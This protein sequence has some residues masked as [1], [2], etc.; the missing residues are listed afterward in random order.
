MNSEVRK[1]AVV[2]LTL[3]CLRIRWIFYIIFTLLFLSNLLINSLLF[4]LRNSECIL[5]K[6][7]GQIITSG[8]HCLMV[9]GV[10]MQHIKTHVLPE[11]VPRGVRL[12]KL[13]TARL[14][15]RCLRL[16][17]VRHLESM[18]CLMRYQSDSLMA[19]LWNKWPGGTQRGQTLTRTAYCINTARP[20]PHKHWVKINTRR[21][22]CSCIRHSWSQCYELFKGHELLDSSFLQ[23]EK[24][25]GVIWI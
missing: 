6:S 25:L 3:F 21:S 12:E 23:N 17:A 24:E 7:R 4:E 1:T 19:N 22:R 2:F 8:R 20:P 18:L 16:Q 5:L 9:R 11:P 13:L 14:W 15:P 10:E